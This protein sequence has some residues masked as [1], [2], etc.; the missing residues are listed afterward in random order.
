MYVQNSSVNSIY[1]LVVNKRVDGNNSPEFIMKYQFANQDYK[2]YNQKKEKKFN[3]KIDVY[4]FNSFL[5]TMGQSSK[6]LVIDPCYDDIGP[7]PTPISTDSSGSGSGT[8]SGGGSTSTYYDSG[9][10]SVPGSTAWSSVG[11]VTYST[12]DGG[13]ETVG[14]VEIGQGCFCEPKPDDNVLKSITGKI[15]DCPEGEMLIPINAEDINP[16][17]FVNCGSFEFY[18]PPL[19]AITAAAVDG[20][21]ETFYSFRIVNGTT[22]T[23]EVYIRLNRVYFTLPSWRRN[24]EDANITAEAVTAANTATHTWSLANFSASK[25]QV[26]DMWINNLKA[27]MTFR[28]GQLTTNAPF[29]MKNAGVYQTSLLTTGDCD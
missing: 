4:S 11:T 16:L 25:E 1:N 24:G 26:R 10:Q 21:E 27:A 19:S 5:N 8:S 28:G 17:I 13:Q 9:T 14:T 29:A 15:G 23:K 3:G 18:K 20:V 6:E 12:T 7:N 22:E 2:D